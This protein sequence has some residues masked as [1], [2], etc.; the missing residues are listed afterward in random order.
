M[1]DKKIFILGRMERMIF[2]PDSDY[3]TSRNA[4]ARS[5]AI[6]LRALFSMKKIGPAWR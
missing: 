5:S 2:R 4:S 3:I 1:H 6:I